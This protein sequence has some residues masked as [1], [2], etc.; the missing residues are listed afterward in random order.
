[1]DSA[2]IKVWDPLVRIGHWSLVA[3]IAL[4]WITHE[5]GA[6]HEWLGYFVLAVVAVRIV[7]GLIGT[8][9][10][11]FVQFI[12]SPLHTVA[13]GKQ[14]L[15][16]REPRHIGHNPLGGWMIVALLVSIVLV[17]ASGWLYTTDQFW[18]VKWVEEVHEALANMML[19]L[20]GLHVGGVIFSSLRHGENLVV[21]MINGRKRAPEPGDIA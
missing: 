7:W 3:G 12:Y 18:G 14:I 20:I 8:R 16:H 11:R 15:T 9:Y 21:A 6:V 17:G 10:A 19:V 2:K 5:A 4:A 1:V 13:Y